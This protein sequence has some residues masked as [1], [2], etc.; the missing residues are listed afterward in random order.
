MPARESTSLHDKQLL[1]RLFGEVTDEE[2]DQILAVT[3]QLVFETGRYVFHQGDRENALYIVLSGR[4]RV[5]NETAE[6]VRIL[7]DVTEG[8]PVGEFSLF[9]KEPRSA[10]VVAIRR[11]VV[12][13]MDEG[14]YQT[15]IIRFPGL[16]HTLTRFVIDR[17]RRNAFQK[18]RTAAPKNIALVNLQSTNDL[19]AWAP[20]MQQQFMDMGIQTQVY[21]HRSLPEYQSQELFEQMEQLDGLNFLICDEQHEAWAHQCIVYC[22]LV[23]LVADFHADPGPYALESRLQLHHRDILHRNMYLLLL[24]REDAGLPRHTS[25]WYQNRNIDL[26]IHLRMNNERDIRRFCRIAS[27][28]ATGLVL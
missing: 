14:D 26:H 2:L 23:V 12:L 3:E 4:L 21:D 10:S 11:S 28:R 22:D 13:E 16:A 27:H 24:H 5:L 6:G 7:G 1:L 25:R 19:L 9:T 15:L 18:N 8:E 17:L 20:F